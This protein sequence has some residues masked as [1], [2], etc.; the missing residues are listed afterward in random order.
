MRFDAKERRI[1]LCVCAAY[2][3][4]YI[5][6]MNYS[7]A[8]PLIMADL[9]L[10]ETALGAVQ[11]VFAV[12]Y[13]VGQLVNGTIAT[14]FDARRYVVSGLIL[15]GTANLLFALTRTVLGMSIVWGLNAVAQAMLFT[16]LVSI[17]SASFDGK[18]RTSVSLIFSV[19][20]VIGH[21][22]SWAIAG[23]MAD[24][25]S[26]KLS[27]VVPGLIM[28]ADA[29]CFYLLMPSAKA[30][31]KTVKAETKRISFRDMLL[32]TGLGFMFLSCIASGFALEGVLTWAPTILNG[33]FSDGGA[34][35]GTML[36]LIIP[37]VKLGG[38]FLCQYFA[39]RVDTDFGKTIMLM[40]GVSFV[41][42][43]LSYAAYGFGSLLFTLMLGVM[44]AAIYSV[45]N[46][47]S[48]RLPVE[49]A[50]TGRVPQIAGIADSMIHLGYAFSD[51]LSGVVLQH[52]GVK[53]VL[54]VWGA[55]IL[56]AVPLML[57]SNRSAKSYKA[58]A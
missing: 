7:A 28:I 33:M 53:A 12:V 11:T 43:G 8:M 20:I 18:K 23:V 3:V 26:W 37:C 58:N 41:F 35:S 42:T 22:L 29:V 51:I 6:R 34:L 9:S 55:A 4:A 52:Y 32:K 10:T 54:A 57:V 1:L 21:L 56:I 31:E 44:C 46:V 5:G 15:S 16:P 49:Y 17:I 13:A 50:G 38:L 27:F 45:T 19:C 25:F 24:L 40:L 30:A 47:Q 36:S 39:R 2:M 48:V 14:R